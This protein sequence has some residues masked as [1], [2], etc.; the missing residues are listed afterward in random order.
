[1]YVGC[2]MLTAHG[3]SKTYTKVTLGDWRDPL[4]PDIEA[5]TIYSQLYQGRDILRYVEY[6]D[7]N[8]TD[9]VSGC[10]GFYLV[11]NNF[12]SHMTKK[13]TTYKQVSHPTQNIL[14]VWASKLLY[15]PS[16]LNARQKSDNSVI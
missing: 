5:Q 2:W 13:E 14:L 9:R 10:L 11:F 3:C 12:F 6:A 15:F 8:L 16:M 7:S 4:D 1:M